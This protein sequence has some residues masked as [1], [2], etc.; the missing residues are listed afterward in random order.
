MNLGKLCCHLTVL[1]KP[2]ILVWIR[3][4]IPEW[5]DE[6]TYYLVG[7][8]EHL[9][10]FHRLGMS[11]SQL[12]FAYF[13]EGWLYHQPVYIYIYMICF[14][15]QD[16]LDMFHFMFRTS[17]NLIK[18]TIN[19]IKTSGSTNSFSWS[20]GQQIRRSLPHRSP[21]DSGEP[22]LNGFVCPFGTWT[23]L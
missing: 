21:A 13:S 6:Y 11:S 12:T 15:V 22:A 19:P 2:G 7:G 16:E 17:M 20:F 14:A 9:L 5:P 4:I 1:P 18:T 3:G 23:M 8:L 10:F